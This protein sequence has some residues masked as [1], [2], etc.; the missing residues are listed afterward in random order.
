MNNPLISII[1]PVFKV[2]PFLERC[3]LSILSQ[4]YKDIEVILVD[5]GSPDRCGDI[6]DGFAKKDNRIIV[7]HQSNMGLP[8]ARRSGFN[9]SSGEYIY[10]L[11]SDDYIDPDAIFSLVSCV[12]DKNTELVVS[13]I[14]I[15]G[16]KKYARPQIL[17]PGYYDRKEIERVLKTNFLFSIP[18]N[19]SAFPLYAWGKLI[20]KDIMDG[21]FEVSTQFRYWEDIP[22]TCFLMNKVQSLE[23]VENCSYHYCVHNGQ[24]TRQ[25]IKDIWHYYVAV[26]NYLFTNDKKQ[27]FKKQLPERIWSFCI[28]SLYVSLSKKSLKDFSET[29]KIITQ[30]DI[31]KKVVLDRNSEIQGYGN[32]FYK[33][34]MRRGWSFIHY[35]F[36]RYGV[37]I[38]LYNLKQLM[39]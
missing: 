29:Y 32:N 2:E 24:V 20:K 10:F 9:V 21:Y 28:N 4:T 8:K 13:G 19:C 22:S 5:D 27:Y 33:F 26:W 30:A 34:L 11:D 7:I 12:I 3:I 14:I 25:P 16:E 36:L 1:V 31:I 39:E 6:C 35:Y 38:K 23:I 15:D 37:I 17:Q 18:N